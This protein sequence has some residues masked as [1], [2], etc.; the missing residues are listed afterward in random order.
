MDYDK[1]EKVL[2]ALADKSR[3]QI[4]ACIEKGIGNPK[5]IARELD[6]H[7]STVE[8]H[9]RVLLAASL[10]EKTPSLTKGGHLTI[11]YRVRGEARQLL[12]AV[13]R[14]LEPL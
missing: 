2:K 9:I 10:V 13:Q 1:T 14:V 6:R 5:E 4:L 12:D 3:L 11:Q 7:R 8:K